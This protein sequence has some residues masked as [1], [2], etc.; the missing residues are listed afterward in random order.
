L[1]KKLIEYLIATR[2]AREKRALSTE[3]DSK[4]RF[5]VTMSAECNL[6]GKLVGLSKV[7]VVFRFNVMTLGTI[8]AFL[9]TTMAMGGPTATQIGGGL[10]GGSLLN[11]SLK[12][13][14][15]F[16]AQLGVQWTPLRDIKQHR[17]RI[18]LEG[19][20]EGADIA[21]KFDTTPLDLFGIDVQG[22]DVQGMDVQ[23]IDVQALGVNDTEPLSEAESGKS[24][25][26]Q[27]ADVTGSDLIVQTVKNML[28]FNL[29]FDAEEFNFENFEQKEDVRSEKED[30]SSEILEI[31]IQSS[32]G[33][34][35]KAKGSEADSR[36][37]K[38]A[39]SEGSTTHM[40]TTHSVTAKH[41]GTADFNDNFIE[42]VRKTI[43]QSGIFSNM[44]REEIAHQVSGEQITNQFERV[45][46]ANLPTGFPTVLTLESNNDCVLL[47]DLIDSSKKWTLAPVFIRMRVQ[48]LPVDIA[49]CDLNNSD[50][51]YLERTTP[52]LEG[53]SFG[54]MLRVLTQKTDYRFVYGEEQKSPDPDSYPD[55]YPVDPSHPDSFPRVYF[56]HNRFSDFLPKKEREFTREVYGY[57]PVYISSEERISEIQRI[58]LRPKIQNPTM[59]M[60]KW[61]G[62]LIRPMSAS[63]QQTLA[64]KGQ[65]RERFD[66]L[67]KDCGWEAVEMF[68]I[69]ESMLCGQVPEEFNDESMLCGQ[70][71]EEKLE[72]EKLPSGKHLEAS[73]PK[74]TAVNTTTPVQHGFTISEK[75]FASL[76]PKTPSPSAASAPTATPS[77]SAPTAT[78]SATLTATKIANKIAN[79]FTKTKKIILIS[80]GS[81]MPF[82]KEAHSTLKRA[83]KM[84][85]SPDPDQLEESAIE[86]EERFYGG[87][88]ACRSMMSENFDEM[89]GDLGIRTK[90]PQSPC[91]CL[92]DDSKNC[93]P[94]TVDPIA[95][96][97]IELDEAVNNPHYPN[98]GVFA[99]SSLQELE[100]QIRAFFG[101]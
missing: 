49:Y 20:N 58:R 1:R 63:H 96:L 50:N 36:T 10:E 94:E 72:S 55:S 82:L 8:A 7:M 28:E 48:P 60:Q 9:G 19:L 97:L 46:R 84:L 69:D 53:C 32:D 2:N 45:R 17:V 11:E 29:E 39:D 83:I 24:V 31:K 64:N 38:Y 42:R 33:D 86:L 30:V 44:V 61:N 93:P 6:F 70:I 68:R 13:P 80:F 3:S 40:W 35:S 52:P 51:L 73:H 76:R 37:L 4:S 34:D 18:G 21:P 57:E 59:L 16:G 15:E 95:A 26:T 99:L 79:N 75:G 89:T 67:S 98:P 43:E 87:F 47:E 25:E 71:S 101:R 27:S 92:D 62:L 78:L 90:T 12:F 85:Y 77:P 22:I 23:G 65:Y 81:H 88:Y 66:F 56:I 41:S 74:N 91:T 5:K 100:L 54:E 14:S